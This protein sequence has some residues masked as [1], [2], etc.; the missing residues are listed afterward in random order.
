MMTRFIRAPSPL[1]LLLLSSSP[2]ISALCFR[3]NGSVD[4]NPEYV[5]CSSD[6]SDPFS[7]IC[8][9]TNRPADRGPD[10]CTPNGLCQVGLKKGEKQGDTAWTKPQCKNKDWQGC[11]EVCGTDD[12]SFVTPCDTPAGNSSRRWCCGFQNKD[13]CN[14]DNGKPIETLALTFG[15]STSSSTLAPVSLPTDS[16]APSQSSPNP[17]TTSVPIMPSSSPFTNP[18]TPQQIKSE[19]EGMSAGAKAGL[20]IGIALGVVALLGMGYF[21]GARLRNNKNNTTATGPYAMMPDPYAGNAY[22]P[23]N[24]Y[25]PAVYQADVQAQGVPPAAMVYYKYEADGGPRVELP[26][27]GRIELQSS[28]GTNGLVEL[29]GG[30]KGGVNVEVIPISEKRPR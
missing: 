13:C 19:D 25:P 4:A 6:P 1:L 29:D 18:S 12:M 7:N 10:I 14:E 11:M 3:P 17:S 5:P 27:N 2:F 24:T 16:T 28:R 26:E 22:P 15:A 8:C 30:E 21:L 20:G 23:P 9:A